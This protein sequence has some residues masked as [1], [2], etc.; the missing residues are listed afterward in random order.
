VAWGKP[1]HASVTVPKL[2]VVVDNELF[3][4]FDGGGIVRVIA[5][6]FDSNGIEMPADTDHVGAIIWHCA[7]PLEW[8]GCKSC[9]RDAATSRKLLNRWPSINSVHES[10]FANRC[11]HSTR[12]YRFG[13]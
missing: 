3:G 8:T 9:H 4:S 7:A 2:N 6:E 1:T 11:C 12:Q 10:I 13:F 5:L